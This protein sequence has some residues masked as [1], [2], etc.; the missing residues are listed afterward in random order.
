MTL[1]LKREK[2]LIPL[3]TERYVRNWLLMFSVYALDSFLSL[4]G[5]RNELRISSFHVKSIFVN[6]SYCVIPQRLN[7]SEILS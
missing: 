7:L 4:Y 2:L 1:F 3:E 5:C 6:S